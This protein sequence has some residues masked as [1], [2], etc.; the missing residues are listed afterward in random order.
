MYICIYRE[1]GYRSQRG[2][3]RRAG[4]RKKVRSLSNKAIARVRE[5]ELEAAAIR[6]KARAEACDRVETCEKEYAAA[7][8][9]ETDRTAAGL[10][11]RLQD[12]RRRTEALVEQSRAE[13]E[14]DMVAMEEAAREKMRE[15]VKQIEWEMFDSCQ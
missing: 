11:A 7:A 2:D 14:D 8:A 5:A 13:A 4:Q 10:T 3:A 6:E 15:A 1:P 9:R 12:M